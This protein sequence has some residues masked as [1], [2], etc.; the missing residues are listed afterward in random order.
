[1][2]IIFLGSGEFGLPSL[3]HLLDCHEVP[4]VITQPDRPAGRGRQQAPTPIGAHAGMAGIPC[5][6]TPDANDPSVI[7]RIDDLNPDVL[8]VIAFGQ[9][10]AP[11]LLKG[12]LSVNLHASLL[13]R[14]RGAAPIHWAIINGDSTTGLSVITLADRIDAGDVLGM[15]ETP[16]RSSETVGELHDRLAGLGPELLEQVLGEAK[17]GELQPV[18]QDEDAATHAPKLGRAD[19]TVHFN[20]AAEAVRNRVHGLTPWPGCDI[21][22]CDHQ[23]R[24]LSV[25]VA[26]SSDTNTN[27]GLLMKDGTVACQPG[28][29]RLIRIQSPGGRPMGF[30]DWLRGHAVDEPGICT[31]L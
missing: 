26:S 3:E 27:P 13:P 7:S 8:V 4:L 22:F 30:E 6:K 16:I 17:Q 29:I 31:P 21:R 15:I 20:Q 25:E 9:K 5:L 2:R 12:R 28:S 24:L 14:Y 18:T 19:G 11:E 1:M 23:L 10:L